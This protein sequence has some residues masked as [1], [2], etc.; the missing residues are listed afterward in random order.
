MAWAASDTLGSVFVNPMN[1][2]R[3]SP[4]LDENDAKRKLN[5]NWHD[6]D[7]NAE[8]RHQVVVPK[9][10]ISPAPYRAGVLLSIGLYSGK[11]R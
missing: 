2:N 9:L 10:A 1:G 8:N 11:I 6:N 3:Y 5:L 4:F 7:W